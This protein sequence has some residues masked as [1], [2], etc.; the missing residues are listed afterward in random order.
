MT[1]TLTP[2]ER[3][4]RTEAPPAPVRPHPA[5]PEPQAC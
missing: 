4:G 2:H 3:D 5:A 1:M